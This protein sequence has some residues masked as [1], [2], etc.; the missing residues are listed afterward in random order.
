MLQ[1]VSMGEL[2]LSPGYIYIYI[3]RLL[4]N[5]SLSMNARFQSQKEYKEKKT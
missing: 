3:Y 5:F 4:C 1:M 2:I